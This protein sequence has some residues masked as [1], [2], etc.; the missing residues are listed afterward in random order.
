[1][2]PGKGRE[3]CCE[4][5]KGVECDGDGDNVPGAADRRCL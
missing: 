3:S 2:L 1:M 4:G 5:S